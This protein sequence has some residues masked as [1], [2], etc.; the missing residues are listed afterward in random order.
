MREGKGKGGRDRWQKGR[1]G[2]VEGER[3]VKVNKISKFVSHFIIAPVNIT[4]NDLNDL[5]TWWPIIFV[6][7]AIHYNPCEPI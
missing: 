4:Q 5:C 3:R 2:E 1:Q 7:L 6:R